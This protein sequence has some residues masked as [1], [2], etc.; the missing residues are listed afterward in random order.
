MR[1]AEFFSVCFLFLAA[2]P[3][4]ALAVSRANIPKLLKDVG[5]EQRLNATIPLETVFRDETG[6]SVSLK[7]YF[8]SRP[9]LLIPVYY[10]C[11]MLCSQIL[12]AVVGGLRPLSLKPGR[13]FEIVAISFNPLETPED[14]KQKRD[15]FSHSYSPRAGPAGWHFLVGSEASVQAVM[16]AIGFHYRYDPENKMYIH[17][18]GIMIATPEG[19]LARYFYGVDFEPKDLKLG[20]IEASHNRIGSPVDQILLFCYHY[21]PKTGK[22]GAVVMNILRVGGLA[23]LLIMGVALFFLWRRDLRIYGQAAR[24]LWPSSGKAR[25]I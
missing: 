4:P 15:H 9:V 18:T 14:A 21:D 10:R 7:K 22:Y 13:D 2:T 16:N 6:A 11:P 24:A 20:L 23:T 3:V 12:S 25:H 5:I 1:L 19:R 8:G 17:A